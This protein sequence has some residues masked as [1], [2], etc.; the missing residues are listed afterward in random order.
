MTSLLHH[1]NND[2]ICSG[3]NEAADVA[4]WSESR[5]RREGEHGRFFIGRFR[6]EEDQGGAAEITGTGSSIQWNL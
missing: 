6:G 2:I 1:H 5:R 4:G 3:D